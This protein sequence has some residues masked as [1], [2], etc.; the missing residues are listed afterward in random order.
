MAEETS[1]TPVVWVWVDQQCC[2]Y[3]SCQHHSGHWP[4]STHCWRTSSLHK[5]TEEHCHCV[6][7]TFCSRA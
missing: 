4:T 7:S 2:G 3:W 6:K 5:Q 1:E